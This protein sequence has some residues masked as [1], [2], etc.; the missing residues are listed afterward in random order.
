MITINE[1][2]M[3]QM[4]RHKV[5]ARNLCKKLGL[6]ETNFSS[7]LRGKRPLPYEELEKVCMYLG[8]TLVNIEEGGSSCSE[9]K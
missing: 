6:T 7:Y 3:L 4:K 9:K 5:R 1:K 8:L 2:I